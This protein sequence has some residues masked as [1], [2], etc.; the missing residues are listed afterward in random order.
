MM[1]SN[2]PWE[3]PRSPGVQTG[4]ILRLGMALLVLAG[5][6]TLAWMLLS[7]HYQARASVGVNTISTIANPWAIVF[8]S[9][10]NAWVAEP[11]CNP[12]PTC[13]N[14]P[15]GAIEEFSLQAGQPHL[16]NTYQPSTGVFNPTFL[17]LDGNGHVWF[18]DPTNNAI[19]ELTI[20]SNTWTQYTTGITAAAAPF[21]LVLDKNG[22]LW[23][24]ERESSKIGFFNTSTH[25]VVETTIPSANGQP[26][27]M[28]YDATNNVVWYTV[29]N[30]P[31]IGTFA[32]TLNGAISIIEHST[33]AGLANPPSPHMITMDSLGNLWYSEQGSD[34]VGK[35]TPGTNTAINYQLAGSICPTPGATPT[36]CP[37]TYI[38]GISIDSTGQVWFDEVQHALLGS[39]NPTTGAINLYA[40]SS[41]SGPGE[42]LAVDSHNNVWVSM[43]FGKLLG[44]LPAA[45]TPS[46]TPSVGGASPSPS[47]SPSPT[48]TGTPPPPPTVPVSLQWYFAEGR[49]GAGFTE[50]LTIGNPLATACQVNIDY[51]YTADGR[52][53]RTRTLAF[54][55]PAST[56]HTEN[57]DQDL[58]TSSRG[59]G[60]DVSAI[61]NVDTV[62]TPNCTGVVAE[63]PMYFTNVFGVNS[64]HDALGAT[65]L[66][67]NFYFADVASMT[68]FQDFLTIL[69]PPGGS[70]AHI[71]VTYYVG[72]AIQG[73]DTLAVPAGTRGTIVPHNFG[74]HVAALVSSD[75]P[76]A[77]ERPEYFANY[78]ANN[79]G[80]VSGAAVVAGVLALGNDWLFAEGYTGG[81]F[82]E[83]FVIANLDTTAHATASVTI[84]LYYSS[85]AASNSF[86]VHVPTLSQYVWN[87]N[88]NAPGQNVSAE[89]TSTGANIVVERQMYFHYLHNAN[90]RSLS[91][92]GGTDATGQP[93]PA[94]K[95]SYS[96]AEGYTNT[97]YDEWLTLQN[98][99]STDETI[100]TMLVNGNGNTYVFSTLVK[101][102][103]R[104]TID[105][106]GIVM[107]N[108]CRPGGPAACWEVSIITQA[109][110]AGAFFVV[111]RPMYFN[112]S[113][114]QGGTDIIGYSGG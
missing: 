103:T 22:N 47:P 48:A 95:S 41:G 100:L 53:P 66:A 39:L 19:G 64:G 90:G 59:S 60:I 72:G 45:A 99:T 16:L 102:H 27:G 36:P 7:T 75:Q 37:V 87:V 32:V 69:N 71:T 26:F 58:G 49:A 29:D 78:R 108:L 113:G 13:I 42:G 112:A 28:T 83:N 30:A 20:G 101:A 91:T 21:G 77:V 50:F 33:A 14:P 3:T 9:S 25:T 54:S 1:Q 106:V 51:R 38:S 10:G 31:A 56:R 17:Q 88:A 109:M 98:P 55:I 61:V 52:A 62:T 94:S 97:H 2:S 57:V 92:T 96:F 34:M 11:N 67:K 35:Y 23:F 84:T 80:T 43:L 81:Q 63:R 44:E 65:H 8:D 12:A 105:L 107:R 76:V 82:Q 74:K 111:E 86:T 4:I 89:I 93:G 114:S 5:S 18:T 85:G 110:T 68:G 24:A 73:T 46:P 40:L 104:G 79:A 70:T 15:S 6:I